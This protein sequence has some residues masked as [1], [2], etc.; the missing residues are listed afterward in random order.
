MLAAGS[1]FVAAE[2]RLLS[3]EH[4]RYGIERAVFFNSVSR[5]AVG[6]N[7]LDRRSVSGA[8]QG[9]SSEAQQPAIS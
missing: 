3:R 1:Y 8:C 4:R 9:R 6:S 2:R 5:S 7:A